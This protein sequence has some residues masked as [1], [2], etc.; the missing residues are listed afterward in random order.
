MPN[1]TPAVTAPNGDVLPPQP[2]IN[3]I[4][5]LIAIAIAKLPGAD[6]LTILR[7]HAV[8]DKQ[9]SKGRTRGLEEGFRDGYERGYQEGLQ[10]GKREAL[11]TLSREEAERATLKADRKS[12]V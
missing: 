9:F 2:D 5:D 8:M 12:V 11:D 1:N 3:S 7:S 10:D 6:G 4:V